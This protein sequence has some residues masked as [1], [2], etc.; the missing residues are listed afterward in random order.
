MEKARIS[1]LWPVM[2]RIKQA[3]EIYKMANGRGYDIDLL[4]LKSRWAQCYAYEEG[5]FGDKV[6]ASL[7]GELVS[8]EGRRLYSVRF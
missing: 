6:C 1:W 7:G 2:R 5:N 3:M 8:A 4:E